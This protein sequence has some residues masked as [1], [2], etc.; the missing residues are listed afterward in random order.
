MQAQKRVVFIFTGENVLFNSKNYKIVK[1]MEIPV[2]IFSKQKQIV[3]G[4]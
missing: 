1:D 2:F 3:P 4:I